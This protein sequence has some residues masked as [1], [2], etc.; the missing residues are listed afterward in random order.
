MRVQKPVCFIVMGYE[1]KTDPVT[2]KVYDLDKSYRSVIKKAVENAGYEAVRSDN[3]M[4]PGTISR[5]MYQN[6]MDAELVVCD[7]TTLNVNAVFELGVRMALR[8]RSTVVICAEETKIPFNLNQE[9]IFRYKHGGEVIDYEDAEDAQA[10]LTAACKAAAASQDP[11]SLIYTL[12]HRELEPPRWLSSAAPAASSLVQAVDPREFVW[13]AKKAEDWVNL[14]DRL[15][16]LHDDAAVA[17]QPLDH[18]FTQQWALATYKQREKGDTVELDD[19]LA[20][21]AILKRLEPAQSTDAETLG[22]WAAIHKRLSE[23]PQ[24]DIAARKRDLDA[25]IASHRKGFVLRHDHYNGVNY[26]FLLIRRALEFAAP[27]DRLNVRDRV[28]AGDA[29]DQIIATCADELEIPIALDEGELVAETRDRL[30]ERFWRISSLAQ[31]LLAREDK[32]YADARARLDALEKRLGEDWMVKTTN[33]Q[34]RKLRSLLGLDAGLSQ[35]ERAVAG[36]R[37]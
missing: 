6:L 37:A 29:W 24:R 9:R 11:D 26:A 25:A 19:L 14:I 4:T 35:D 12:F 27:D 28:E 13:K 17:K 31:A 7:L 32:R 8:P 16:K 3:M 30:T 1:K 15:K 20:A 2:S 5:Q 23:H 18:F 21:R 36:A 22:L 10:M 34:E 33:K